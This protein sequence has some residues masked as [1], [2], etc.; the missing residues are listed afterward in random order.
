MNIKEATIKDMAEF[1]LMGNTCFLHTLTGNF[2]HYPT[3]IDLMFGEDNPWQDI[4]DKVENNWHDYIRIEPMN[5]HQSYT[6]MESFAEQ[7]E[8]VGFREKLFNVLNRPK[9]FRN[10]NHLIHQSDFRQEWFHFRQARNEA[11]VKEQLADHGKV[12]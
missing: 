6:V 8:G 3:E 12:E 11:W 10:F 9:P 4:I 5:S 2:E 7:L 1:L